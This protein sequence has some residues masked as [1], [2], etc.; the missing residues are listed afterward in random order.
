MRPP[1]KWQK[2]DPPEKKKRKA[3]AK[4]RRGAAKKN[5]RGLGTKSDAATPASDGS[6]PADTATEAADADDRDNN[7]DT[8]GDN[9]E[10]E[11]PPMPHIPRASCAEPAIRV[12]RFGVAQSTSGARATKSSPIRADGSAMEPIELDLTPRP[13]RRQLFS[14]PN[15]TASYSEPVQSAAPSSN[16]LPTFVRRSP[17]LN[18]TIDVLAPSVPPL[19]NQYNETVDI[20]MEDDLDHIFGRGCDN[21]DVQFP[22]TTPT[23]K[24]RS[25]RLVWK[26]PSKTPQRAFGEAL[27]PNIQRLTPG[28]RTPK[29]VS[30]RQPTVAALLGTNKTLKDMTPFTRSIHEALADVSGQNPQSSPHGPLGTYLGNALKNDGLE[31]N[32]AFDFPDLPTLNGSSPMSNNPLLQFDFSELTTDQLNTDFND[33]FSTD[34]PVPSSPPPGFFN[35]INSHNDCSEGFWGGLGMENGGFEQAEQIVISK[36]GPGQ[37]LRRSPRKIRGS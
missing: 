30:N 6:S 35:F 34:A 25:D 24:R 7:E 2:K 20:V 12:P 29:M 31:N 37:V 4:P 11:L 8:G 9:N 32:V 14:S 27:S 5:D 3:R 23:P 28:L 21:I 1:E 26:T 19:S 22:P 33:V 16:N 10:P 13:L 36:P 18:K 17:R 15:K